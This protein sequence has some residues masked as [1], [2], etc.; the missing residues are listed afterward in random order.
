MLPARSKRYASADGDIPRQ[1]LTGTWQL[2]LLVMVVLVLFYLIFPKKVLLQRLY[3]QEQLD[4]LSLSYLQNIYRAD[5]RNA[6]AALLLARY[7]AQDMDPIELEHMVRPHLR[8]T[9]PRRR[10]IAHQL[11]LG[12]FERQLAGTL[13]AQARA[14]LRDRLSELIGLAAKDRIDESLARR[15]A[16][17]AYKL[18]LNE[19]GGRLLA[20]F[21]SALTPA[22][23]EQLGYEALGRQEYARASYYFMLAGERSTELVKIRRYFQLGVGAYMSGGLYREA[24][25]AA[26]A[27]RRRLRGDLATLRYLVRVAL[28]AGDPA[29]ASRYASQLV[30]QLPVDGNKP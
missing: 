11:M 5:T 3:A 15:Y 7:Q 6:D 4:D 29:L 21:A 18:D 1:R 28:A 22:E 27:H 23:L 8:S 2:A 13:P 24:L 17:L 9:D 20:R 30:F 14:R 25:V 10:E 19:L 26:E 12:A 16:R